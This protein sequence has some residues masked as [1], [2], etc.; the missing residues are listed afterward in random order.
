MTRVRDGIVIAT[1]EHGKVN[2]D[3]PQHSG[4]EKVKL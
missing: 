1:C 2:V 3:P 4:P